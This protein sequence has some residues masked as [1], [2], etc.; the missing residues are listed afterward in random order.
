[1]NCPAGRF[2]ASSAPV[3]QQ[4]NLGMIG[5]GTVGSGVYHALTRNGGLLASRIGIRVNIRKVAVKAFDEPRPYPIAKSL[6]TLDWQE[7]V[8]DPQVEMVSE[9]VGGT[10]IARTMVL[11]ALKLGKPVITANKALLSAHGEE[12]FEAAREYGT[13]LYYE[14]SVCGGIPIIKALR[15]GFVGN[16]ITHLY[17][18]V[19]GTCNYILTRMK[20][21]GADFADVLKDAQAQGYAEAEPSL[22]VDGYD[23]QHK[24][25]ILASLAHGFWVNPHDVHVE[26]IR[27]VTRADIQFAQQLGYTIKLLGIIKTGANRKESSPKRGAGARIQVSVYPTLIPNAHVLA[28][29]NHVFN[30]V[31]VRG[32]VVG[33]T[34]FYGRGAG[35][36]ATASA[37]L[38]DLADGAL[39]LKFGT[40]H[41][42]PPFVPHERDGAVMPIAESVSRYFIRLNVVDAPGTLARISRI[43][44]DARI[45]ISSVIQPEGHVGASVPL[46]LMLHDAPNG[47]VAKALKKIGALPVVKGAP[48]MLRVEDFS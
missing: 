17:G 10:G 5:G 33:D 47:A 36:D 26:G 39:D 4:V 32:D 15:E 29:V 9:L 30:A 13:N 31:F 41:R 2:P 24:I 25:G 34:L 44:G 42:V 19:N 27:H 8:N 37:V 22:D 40:K 35:K 11:A 1:M 6:M 16:R 7:V 43:L 3:M 18:I 21:E 46:I 38:S 45:G 48:V 23:A 20:L 14:A 12:L 28:S